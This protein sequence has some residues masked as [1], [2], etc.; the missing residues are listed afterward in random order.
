MFFGFYIYYR[1]DIKQISLTLEHVFECTTFIVANQMDLMCEV[2]L[3]CFI[4]LRYAK[5]VSWMIYCATWMFLSIKVSMDSFIASI[6]DSLELQIWALC[7]VLFS[8]MKSSYNILP[9]ECEHSK[10]EDVYGLQYV[11]TEQTMFHCWRQFIWNQEQYKEVYWNRSLIENRQI[12][13]PPVLHVYQYK[14][15]AFK[16]CRRL[17][18]LIIGEKWSFAMMTE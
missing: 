14:D 4:Y 2:D 13:L 15:L 16:H 7:S 3:M 8:S 11:M 5:H 10:V 6:R 1:N 17:E 18:Y 12:C 9:L